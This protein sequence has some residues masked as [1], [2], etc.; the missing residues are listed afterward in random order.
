MLNTHVVLPPAVHKNQVRQHVD[1]PQQIVCWAYRIDRF[2]RTHTVA[3]DGL[4]QSHRLTLRARKDAN[5][6][7]HAWGPGMNRR[8]ACASASAAEADA[9]STQRKSQRYSSRLSLWTSS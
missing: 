6:V 5:H 3:P 1:V 4:L 7:A 8:I 2:G 9:A